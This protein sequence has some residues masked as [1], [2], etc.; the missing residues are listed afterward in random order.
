MKLRLLVTAVVIAITAIAAGAA[1]SK[2]P[3]G[4]LVQLKSTNKGKILVDPHGYT[5][6]AFGPDK[7]NKDTVTNIRTNKE[8]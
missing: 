7:K 8:K 6:Y 2:A 1:G 4:T 5:L 3:A